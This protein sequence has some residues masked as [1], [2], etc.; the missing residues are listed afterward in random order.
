VNR[1]VVSCGVRINSYAQVEESL[2]FD[3]VYV[4]RRARLRRTI[5]DKF[6]TIPEGM[7]IGFDPELDRARRLTVTP[8]GI[9]VVP[10]SMKVQD[11]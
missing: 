11:P 5:V 1:C 7:E 10:R 4:G 9:T 2:L 6:A 3:G 8:S